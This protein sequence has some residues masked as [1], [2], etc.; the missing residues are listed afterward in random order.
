MHVV[1]LFCAIRAPLPFVVAGCGNDRAPAAHG[2]AKRRFHRG[3]LAA[4]VKRTN[5]HRCILSPGRNKPP[6]GDL[7]PADRRR[8]KLVDLGFW[9]GSVHDH[10]N[11]S[12]GRNVVRLRERGVAHP[13]NIELDCEL[14]RRFRH[15]KPAAHAVRL[16][17][18][19][20]WFGRVRRIG[21][22]GFGG[23]GS[24]LDADASRKPPSRQPGS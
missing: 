17:R 23:C 15:H 12:G 1:G 8:T 2:S 18:S 3:R 20:G 13:V 16:V 10:R 9:S 5:R 6:L 11:R 14:T 24:R 4:R 22:D 19:A 21:V 7:Q